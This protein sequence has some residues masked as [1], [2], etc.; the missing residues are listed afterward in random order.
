MINFETFHSDLC[1]DDFFRN[2]SFYEI[3]LSLKIY[4]AKDVT[5][6]ANFLREQGY[7]FDNLEN[8]IYRMA[9]FEDEDFR[10]ATDRATYLALVSLKHLGWTR[11][12]EID[13]TLS[14]AVDWICDIFDYPN[15]TWNMI[16]NY[17]TPRKKEDEGIER[18]QN[19]K[20]EKYLDEYKRY[21][22]IW[23]EVKLDK[24]FELFDNKFALIR[25]GKYRH[26]LITGEK[27]GDNDMSL[28]IW[29]D[30][31]FIEE[32]QYKFTFGSRE[33]MENFII[34]NKVVIDS[35]LD[36]DFFSD[37]KSY[38]SVFREQFDNQDLFEHTLFFNPFTETLREKTEEWKKKCK[39]QEE[40]Q[41]SAQVPG[42][43]P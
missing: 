40:K 21:L 19:Y 11:E 6:I 13:F 30:N 42:E 32:K 35:C 15:D 8:F 18:L 16:Y 24:C 5:V 29:T 10:L 38:I 23:S 34:E 37:E 20:L 39:E 12:Q 22:D 14:E 9:F 33:K 7:R 4:M 41:T 43:K 28:R 1:T 36:N 26:H 17:Y 27:K 2:L 31:I 25:N 3:L